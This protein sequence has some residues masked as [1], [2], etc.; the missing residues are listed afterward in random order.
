MNGPGG[1]NREAR[2]AENEDLFRRM[3][4]RLRALAGV[5]GSSGSP[6]GPERFLCECS[7]SSCSRV[8]ELTPEEYRHVRAVTRRFLVA[9]DESHT[10]PDLERVVERHESYWIVEKFGEAGEEADSLADRNADP[11]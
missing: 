9:P 8:L 5:G 4:E 1:P 10:S 11:L 3:N 6:E 2:A 7:T